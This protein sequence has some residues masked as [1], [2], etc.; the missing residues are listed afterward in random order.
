MTN[1]YLRKVKVDSS[2]I[3]WSYGRESEQWL[4][5]THRP[6]FWLN[7]VHQSKM[8]LFLSLFKRKEWEV[9]SQVTAG[10]FWLAQ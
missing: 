1:H 4:L 9:T 7:C 5:Y 6:V 2:D 8:L 3:W 10:Y